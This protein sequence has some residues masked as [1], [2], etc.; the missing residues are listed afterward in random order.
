MSNPRRITLR[1]P[2]SIHAKLVALADKE[3][4]SLNQ[5]IVLNL[6]NCLQC[7]SIEPHTGRDRA[8]QETPPAPPKWVNYGSLSNG[9]CAFAKVLTGAA[10]CLPEGHAGEHMTDQDRATAN[11]RSDQ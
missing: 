2:F 1:L 9:R 8:A 4:V 10:C 11:R 5:Y 3:G 7:Y 6:S